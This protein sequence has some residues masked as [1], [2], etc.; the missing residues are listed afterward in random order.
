MS[1][2]VFISRITTKENTSGTC[3]SFFKV[4]MYCSLQSPK[5]MKKLNNII[6]NNKNIDIRKTAK[7]HIGSCLKFWAPGAL[8]RS[9]TLRP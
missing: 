8:Y 7:P 6:F 2:L 4:N 9:L 5:F 1:R 3:I